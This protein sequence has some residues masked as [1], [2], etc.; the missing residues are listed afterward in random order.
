MQ[1]PT[2]ILVFVILW[3]LSFFLVLPIGHR[4]QEDDGRVEPGT[5]ASAPSHF[6]WKKKALVTTIVAVLLTVVT[7]LIVTNDV[8]GIRPS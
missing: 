4:S 5:V 8:F 6:D 1:W 2:V 3:W 7:V